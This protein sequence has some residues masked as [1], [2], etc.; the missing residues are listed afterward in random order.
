MNEDVPS[1]FQQI[2]LRNKVKF[3]SLRDHWFTIHEIQ[4]ICQKVLRASSKRCRDSNSLDK[5]AIKK[6]S[7]RY[8]IDD[9]VLGM[10]VDDVIRGQPID[11]SFGKK[12]A[13]YDSSIMDQVALRGN[14]QRTGTP[15]N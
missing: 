9:D 5:K 7:E 14:I 3:R 6:F 2:C 12:H 15:L 4:W 8:N 13:Q 10:W 1:I 11:R